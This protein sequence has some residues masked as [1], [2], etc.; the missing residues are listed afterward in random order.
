MRHQGKITS[1]K[2]DQGFGFITP[3]LG[4]PEVFVH[5]K[6]FANRQRRPV[7]DQIVSY[8]LSRDAKG[9]LQANHVDFVGATKRSRSAAA[10]GPSP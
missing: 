4:G 5:I 7:V 10:T 2:D 8:E 3:N 6:S 9:R 1:W